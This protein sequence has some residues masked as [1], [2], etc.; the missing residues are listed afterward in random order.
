[1]YLPFVR[2]F[3]TLYLRLD[4]P[5]IVN[6]KGVNLCVKKLYLTNHSANLNLPTY[7]SVIA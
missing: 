2:K 7:V 1:M 5:T 6:S 4:V 3:D